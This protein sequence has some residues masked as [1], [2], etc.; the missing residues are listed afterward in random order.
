MSGRLQASGPATGRRCWF[1]RHLE[2][3]DGDLLLDLGTAGEPLGI[4]PA[5]HHFLALAL[6]ALAL[7]A[8]SLK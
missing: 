7:A 8:T 2:D 5:L 4:G 1:R 3:G 6:P